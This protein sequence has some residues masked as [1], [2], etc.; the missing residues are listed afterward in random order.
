MQILKDLN[1]LIS[2]PSRSEDVKCCKEAL[3][4]VLGLAENFGLETKIGRHG[5]VGIAELGEGEKTVGILVHVDVVSEGNVSLWKH[6]PF[7]LSEEEGMLYGRGIVD[8]KGPVIACLYALKE[9]KE[10]NLPLKKKIRMIIGTAE[11][12]EWTDMEH[13]KEEFAFPDYGFTPDG[14]FPIYNRENGYMDI[15]L[16]FREAFPDG[17]G[18]FAGGGA[19]NS[20]PSHAEYKVG[21]EVKRFEGKGAHSSTPELGINAINL[22]CRE[23][24]QYGFNFAKLIN[25]Y[26]PDGEYASRLNY[27]RRDGRPNEEKDLT[28]VPTVLRQEG[29]EIVIN[30]NARQAFE[31]P[32]ESIIAAL[33][34]KQTEYGYTVSEAETQEAVYVDENQPWMQRMKKVNADYGMG[35]ECLLASGSSYA[36]SMPDIVSW[37]PVFPEEPDCAHMENERQSTSSFLKTVEI[38]RDYLILECQSPD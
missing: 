10:K 30:L 34:D 5:D 1:T 35:D 29:D 13:Y 37:G 23:V 9:I 6:E 2:Y 32:A 24:A 22:L 18:G 15:E 3:K 8:D 27:V 36:K 25:T 31:I 17:I 11:E 19:T 7:K 28:I 33:H 38:Y 26:F 16:K 4:Y 12:V 21:E 14:N 20:V